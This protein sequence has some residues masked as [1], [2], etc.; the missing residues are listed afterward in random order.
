MIKKQFKKCSSLVA[1]LCTLLCFLSFS[2]I[3]QA[4]A[5]GTDKY[6]SGIT[7]T[8]TAGSYVQTDTAFYDEIVANYDT[9]YNTPETALQ[10]G[11]AG[12]LAAFRDVV[13]G[14]W[15]WDPDHY[16]PGVGTYVPDIP[17][18]DFSGKYVKLTA[19]IDL[20]G[21]APTVTESPDGTA[22]DSTPKFTIT[23][24]G[25]LDNVWTPIGYVY[26]GSAS[27]PFNGT[28]DG[29]FHVIQHMVI[30]ETDPGACVTGLFRRASSSDALI[31]NLG[32]DAN[33]YVLTPSVPMESEIGTICGEIG[34]TGTISCCYSAA[35]IY[36][37]TDGS[38]V[39]GIVGMS[40]G[41]V[42]NC[43]NTGNIFVTGT[44]FAGGIRGYG[45]GSG[46][47]GSNNCYNVG[48]IYACTSSGGQVGNINGW[49]WTSPP[50]T[51][52]KVTN[53]YYDDAVHISLYQT[54]SDDAGDIND[55]GTP[56]TTA[57]MQGDAAKTTMAGFADA[58]REDGAP[59][60][61]FFEDLYPLLWG[62][63]A[64]A[65]SSEKAILSFDIPQQISSA[66]DEEN[67]TISVIMPAGTDLT[68]LMPAITVSEGAAIDPAS[69]A[70]GDFTDPMTYTVTAE[71]GTTQAYVV[72]VSL[73]SS[74]TSTTTAALSPDNPDTGDTAL[75]MLISFGILVLLSAMALVVLKKAPGTADVR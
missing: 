57:Q 17:A 11:T 53:C 34:S 73:A 5:A 18:Q 62:G 48:N 3:Q 35:T 58:T 37:P 22:S 59:V 23:V 36:A 47:I 6:L 25:T 30:L 68:G 50:G 19:D 43:Y 45:M 44:M 51:D 7:V 28:F 15:I 8:A 33:S 29:D 38:M 27:A 39:G 1:C 61:K 26:Y 60:W 63:P 14:T 49:K 69:G 9:G 16:A 55:L 46:D 67:H 52:N 32:I 21:T 66:I 2:C 12:E 20:G 31:E 54:N 41:P 70:A 4:S 56:L 75:G 74:N 71:D 24:S 40:N 42:E 10:I 65:L 72:T 64:P 13:N